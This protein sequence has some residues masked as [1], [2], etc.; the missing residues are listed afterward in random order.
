L[1]LNKQLLAWP[2]EQPIPATIREFLRTEKQMDTSSKYS[3]FGRTDIIRL[4]QP[5]I[6]IVV[7]IWTVEIIDWI[8]FGGHLDRLGIIP[9]DMN[10]L[11]GIFFAPILHGGFRHLMANTVP[12]VVLGLLILVRNRRNF[13]AITLVIALLSGL[14]IWFL[15]PSQTVHFGASALIFGFFGYLL[16]NA[17]YERSAASIAIAILVIVLYGGILTG[18]LPQGNGISWQ[19]HLFGLI[20]GIVAAR[21]FSR[22][23]LV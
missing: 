12:L 2:H 10:G 11:R 9:R 21:Y 18:L 19:G 20:S 3:A 17:Y 13:W 8:F 22:P 6:I 14:A 5:L 4:I 15:G 16:A 7:L 1:G 23:A